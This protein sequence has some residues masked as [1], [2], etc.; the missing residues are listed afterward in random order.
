M[1]SSHQAAFAKKP[2]TNKKSTAKLAMPSP[3][4]FG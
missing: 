4:N 3:L 2:E 1:F